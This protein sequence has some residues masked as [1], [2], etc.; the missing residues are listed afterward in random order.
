MEEPIT[1][2]I[3]MMNGD[4]YECKM[5]GSASLLELQAKLVEQKSIPAVK[6]DE[7]ALRYQFLPKD[8]DGDEFVLQHDATMSNLLAT[9]TMSK[10]DSRSVNLSAYVVV[11]DD[12]VHSPQGHE[13]SATGRQVGQGGSE[14]HGRVRAHPERQPQD[15]LTAG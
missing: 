1:V 6:G 14:A 9:F 3:G 5:H 15:D 10:S 7:V 4:A 12:S 2:S 11:V 13:A 8:W